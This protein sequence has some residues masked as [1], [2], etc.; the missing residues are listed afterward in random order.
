MRWS[1]HQ[2]A[3]QLNGRHIAF[4]AQPYTGLPNL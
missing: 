3:S 4:K 1:E 2:V